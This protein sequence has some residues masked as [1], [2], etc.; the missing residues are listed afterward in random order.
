MGKS[1]KV[2][3]VLFSRRG[4]DSWVESLPLSLHRRAHESLWMILT[5]AVALGIMAKAGLMSLSDAEHRFV[6]WVAIGLLF[7]LVG[8]L[9][10]FLRRFAPYRTLESKL[11]LNRDVRA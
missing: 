2:A 1:A 11:G 6:V 5:A 8:I 10:N 3:S 7:Y 4:W 9:D